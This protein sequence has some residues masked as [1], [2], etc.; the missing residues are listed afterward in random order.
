MDKGLT[1]IMCHPSTDNQAME[2]IFHWGYHGEEELQGLL[3]EHVKEWIQKKDIILTSYQE[4][5]N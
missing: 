4:I 2:E 1:E 5:R 3:S